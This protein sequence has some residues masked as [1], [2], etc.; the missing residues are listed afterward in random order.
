MCCLNVDGECQVSSG[1]DDI[2]HCEGVIDY[3]HTHSKK[4]HPSIYQEMEID[5]AR[6]EWER[7][8]SCRT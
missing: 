6:E 7:Y 1:Q 5:P 4:R 3:L 8:N 2:H